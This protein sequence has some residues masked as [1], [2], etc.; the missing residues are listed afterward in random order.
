MEAETKKL[1]EGHKEEIK[2]IENGKEKWNQRPK[3]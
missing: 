1:K 2:R 3:N